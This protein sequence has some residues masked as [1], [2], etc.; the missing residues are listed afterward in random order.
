MP[1]P[2]LDILTMVSSWASDWERGI[3]KCVNVLACM[4]V[5][6]RDVISQE[7]LMYRN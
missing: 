3:S 7:K 1:P 6:G 2:N 4:H 5:T